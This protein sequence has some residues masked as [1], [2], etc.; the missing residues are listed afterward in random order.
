MGIKAVPSEEVT[1]TACFS[2]FSPGGR[3]YVNLQLS[4]TDAMEL[5][6]KKAD[7]RGCDT[8][9][10]IHNRSYELKFVLRGK[11]E[12]YKSHTTM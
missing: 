3:E 1:I 11:R 6:L 2:V 9:E 8:A 5:K 4:S 7:R 12:I 10:I